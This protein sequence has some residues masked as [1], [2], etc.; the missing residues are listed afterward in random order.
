[1]GRNCR[2]GKNVTLDGAYIWDGVVI[3]DGSDIRT[4][5]LA[6]GVVVGQQCKIEAGAL[7]SFGVKITSG[8]TVEEGKRITRSQ[9]EDGS[10]AT[11]DARVVGEDGEGCE[12]VHG[13]EDEDGDDAVSVA[14]S[15]LGMSPSNLPSVGH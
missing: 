3:G 9:R 2:V 6:D 12:F 14:S 8:T 7:L 15:G 10:P 13:D 5:I 1:L 4:A 11:N